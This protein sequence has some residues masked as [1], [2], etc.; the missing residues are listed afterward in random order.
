VGETADIL[1]FDRDLLGACDR[2][3]SDLADAGVVVDGETLAKLVK[4]HPRTI[5]DL[6][7]REMVVKVGT[8]RYDLTG[9]LQAYA[10]H[11]REMAAGRGDEQQQLHLT[12]ERARLAK[13]QADAQ[14]LK[15]AALRRDLVPAADVEREWSDTLR[16]LRS[17][18]LA[19]P[20]RLR[21]SLVHLTAADVAAIDGEL[22]RTLEEL[23]HVD[24]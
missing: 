11:L 4:V 12:A 7:Q 22:R 13:E 14:A 16:Q 1:K 5:R 24:D 6:A 19:L 3:A 20:S 18:I 15:N 21:Q 2:F 9:S 23:A 17:K 8:D 10:T